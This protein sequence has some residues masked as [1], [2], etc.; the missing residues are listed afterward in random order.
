MSDIFR[1]VDEEVRKDQ[2]LTLWNRYGR[3]LI[4]AAVSVVVAT[5]GYQGWSTWS[6]GQRRTDATQFLS[7]LELLAQDRPGAS[8]EVFAALGEGGAAGYA[9]LAR[10]QQGA[11]LVAAGDPAAAAVVY[12]RVAEDRSVDRVL[13]DLASLMAGFALIDTAD[14]T[15]VNSRLD[16]LRTAG[17]PWR[18]SATE[19]AGLAALRYGDV[20]SARTMFTALTDDPGTPSGIRARAAELLAATDGGG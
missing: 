16:P 5:A 1:E 6:L 10:L 8:A 2:A 18:F 17:N 14:L 9:A 4:A 3:Y 7:G 12:D 13:R 19:L 15:S 11:A 20:E